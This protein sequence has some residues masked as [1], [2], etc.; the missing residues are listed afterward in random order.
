MRSKKCVLLGFSSLSVSKQQ[1]PIFITKETKYLRSKARTTMAIPMT[2]PLHGSSFYVTPGTMETALN[3]HTPQDW[4]MRGSWFLWEPQLLLSPTY[5]KPVT[6]YLNQIT[7]RFIFPPL[8]F[9]ALK[10]SNHSL[11]N[12]RLM[13]KEKNLNVLSRLV[14]TN[15]TVARK[16]QKIPTC[17]V[18]VSTR[19][20]KVFWHTPGSQM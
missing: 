17:I 15:Y 16:P 14:G 5:F 7:L 19:F 20:Q 3:K 4:A 6:L 8:S 10:N 11:F 18:Q 1:P 13:D 12:S 9:L 2:R